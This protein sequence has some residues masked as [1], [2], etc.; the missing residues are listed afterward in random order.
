MR[1]AV[2]EVPVPFGQVPGGCG[3]QVGEMHRI[4]PAGGGSIVEVH[5]GQGEDDHGMAAG[6]G[7]PGGI[8]HGEGDAVGACKGVVVGGGL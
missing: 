4:L 3:T 6:I 2:P 1:S 5:H 8:G 7:A